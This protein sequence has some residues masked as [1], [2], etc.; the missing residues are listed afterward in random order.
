M[1]GYQYTIP[2]K[3]VS[4][5]IYCQKIKLVGYCAFGLEYVHTQPSLTIYN[6]IGKAIANDL[7]VGQRWIN[8]VSNLYASS[9]HRF[10]HV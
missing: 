4:W 2:F 10:R 3:S 5:V 7:K 1:V 6:Q 9:N 8:K